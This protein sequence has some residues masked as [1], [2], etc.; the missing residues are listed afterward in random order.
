MSEL[1]PGWHPDPDGGDE[2]R[3]WDGDEWTEDT[4]PAPAATPSARRAAMTTAT[5]HAVP[6]PLVG[7][8]PQFPEPTFASQRPRRILYA[9]VGL[10]IALLVLAVAMTFVRPGSGSHSSEAD[11]QAAGAAASD[12]TPDTKTDHDV[13]TTAPTAS[14]TPTG[15]A[16]YTESTGLYRIEAGPDW[17]L[18]SSTLT[19]TPLWTIGAKTDANVNIV[20][21]VTGSVPEGTTIEQFAQQTVAG[22][23]G[24]PGLTVTGSTPTQLA[25]GTPAALI[26]NTLVVNGITRSQEVLVAVKGTTAVTI[27]VSS[28]PETATATFAATD[29]Y[30]RSLVIL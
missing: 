6:D 16:I 11:D 24:V 23:S 27:T 28:M 14:T 15:P 4:M 8:N 3:W 9:V 12:T 10:G 13:T 21:I 2:L 29:P 5:G 22:I 20:N 30:I 25:D 19:G 1:A 18:A 26:T 17:E 7:S